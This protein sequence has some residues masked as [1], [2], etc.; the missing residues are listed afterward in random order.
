MRQREREVIQRKKEERY[1]QRE[2]DK[3]EGKH[4]H[5]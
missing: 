1:T 3:Q 5:K 2:R 4:T